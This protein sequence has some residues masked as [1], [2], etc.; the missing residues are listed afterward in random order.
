LATLAQ[1]PVQYDDI[2]SAAARFAKVLTSTGM[3]GARS[4]SEKCHAG[5]TAQPTW[6]A[7]DWCAA[8]DYAAAHVDAEVGKS[9]GWPPNPYFQ[10]QAENQADRYKEAGAA[11]YFVST[12]L[13][14]IKVAAESAAD[15]AVM[16]AIAKL[17]LQASQAAPPEPSPP[18][19]SQN[20]TQQWLD[21]ALNTQSVN[22]VGGNP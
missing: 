14:S 17:K 16:A 21:N 7:A 19:Q 2:E 22:R 9:A 15:D 13:T 11:D 5:V 4:L 8:F 20:L 10:F 6:A 3:S 18:E 12:R 1:T